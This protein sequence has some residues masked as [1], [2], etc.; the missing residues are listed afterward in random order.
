MTGD[1]KVVSSMYFTI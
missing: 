1:S